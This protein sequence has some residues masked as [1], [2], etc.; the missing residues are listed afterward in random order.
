MTTA[1]ITTTTTKT[2]TEL[3][4]DTLGHAWDAIRGGERLS[5]DAAV[6]TACR[7][8][9]DAGLA[10]EAVLEEAA[11]RMGVDMDDVLSMCS[12]REACAG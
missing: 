9:M 11:A 4:A 10:L 3:L 6:W 7:A 2:P 1:C 12:G 5:G 8:L